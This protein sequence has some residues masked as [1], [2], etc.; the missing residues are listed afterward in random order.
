[1]VGEYCGLSNAGNN[2]CMP[3][4]KC[5]DYKRYNGSTDCPKS[6]HECGPCFDGLELKEKTTG[7]KFSKCRPIQGYKAPTD[8]R[9]SVGMGAEDILTGSDEWY[10]SNWFIYGSVGILCA[11]VIVGAS[12]CGYK[13]Y[14]DKIQGNQSINI[15]NN[16]RNQ[17]QDF[18]LLINNLLVVKIFCSQVKIAVIGRLIHFFQQCRMEQNYRSDRATFRFLIN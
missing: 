9:S 1:M 3:C 12:C 13:V 8:K 16:L 10:E 4:G 5:S 14:K 15:D 2:I 6:G 11:I 7:G 17:C 18:Q